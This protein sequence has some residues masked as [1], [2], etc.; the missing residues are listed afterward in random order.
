MYQA[1]LGFVRTGHFDDHASF[2]G[3]MLDA[4]F[5][6]APFLNPYWE[7]D[8]RTFEDSGEYRVV[9]QCAED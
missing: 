4:G 5:K 7:Q 1:G 8:G 6:R 2:D 3:M 9:I